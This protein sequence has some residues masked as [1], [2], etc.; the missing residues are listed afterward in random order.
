[1]WS[2]KVNES[3]LLALLSTFGECKFEDYSSIVSEG[4]TKKKKKKSRRTFKIFECESE[5]S[6]YFIK[7]GKCSADKCRLLFLSKK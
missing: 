5:P 7:A 3:H 2:K 6:T 1:M 4:W